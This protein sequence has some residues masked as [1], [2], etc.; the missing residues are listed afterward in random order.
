MLK[1]IKYFYDA[2]NKK[3]IFD[4]PVFILSPPR[5]GSTLL[6]EEMTRFNELVH[7][8]HE[9]DFVWWEC[10][11]YEKM[12]DPSDYIGGEL[13]GT[14]NVELLRDKT[15][16]ALIESTCANGTFK[17]KRYFDK[18]ISNCF[19]LALI[20][21]AFPTAQYLFL[22]RDPSD[23]ISSMIEGWPFINRFGKS[24]LSPVLNALQ[25]R[26]I[27]HWT[28]PAPPGWQEQV[29]RPLVEICAWS[30]LQ[31]VEH[32]L[33]FFSQ[34]KRSY[35]LVKYEDLVSDPRIVLTEIARSFDLKLT[36]SILEYAENP[37]LSATT[38]TPPRKDKW[39]DLYYQE[40]SSVLPMVA[41]TAR[42]LGYHDL[43]VSE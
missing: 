12:L 26:T 22:V 43:Q 30:W 27:E 14:K 29:S 5:S 18:T 20:E 42:K 11:P 28:Y 39:R 21:R 36:A 15:Y 23:N 8:G 9:S 16:Q 3:R 13:I 31:H 6:F 24:Q 7:F 25:K 38:I 2:L 34:R 17:G 41:Q 10:F 19:H 4:K 35:L 33:D 40:I 37:S 1:L 32:V